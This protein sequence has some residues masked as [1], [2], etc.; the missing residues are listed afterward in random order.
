MTSDR[1]AEIEAI[2]HQTKDIELNKRTAFLKDA[3]A[4]DPSLLKEVESLLKAHEEAPDFF[5]KPAWSFVIKKPRMDK[6]QLK[7]LIPEPGL[8]F[9]K[10]GEFK[11]IRRIGQGGMGEVFLAVQES[12]NRQA[13]IKVIRL[14]RAHSLDTAARFIREIEAISKLNHPNIVTIYNS[15]EEQGVHYY[16]MELLSGKGMDE[17][18]KEDQSITLDQKLFWIKEIAWALDSAHK[19]G[20]IHR[21]V[22]P[23]NIQIQKDGRPVLLD[24]GVARHMN[25]ATLTLSGEFRGTPHYAS[26]EQVKAKK[27]EITALTD[28]YSLGVTLYEAMTRKVPFQGETTD[29]V[30]L[31]ILEKDPQKPRRINPSISPDL[32]TVILKAMEKAPEH[33]YPTMAELAQDL[34]RVI[35]RKMILAKP[36]GLIKSAWKKSKRRPLVS[37]MIG[38][39]V[40]ALLYVLWS[41]PQILWERN[42]AEKQTKAA[43][44]AK[45]Q[46]E[47]E[48]NKATIIR[49]YL[50]TMLSSPDPGKDGKEVR[51]VDL[52]DKFA[53]EVDKNFAKDPEI[54]ASIH[55]TLGRTYKGLGQYTAA[56]KQH[57]AALKIYQSLW[58]KDHKDALDTMNCLAVLYSLLGR[59]QEA[60]ELFSQVLDTHIREFGEGNLKTTAIMDNLATVLNRL[61]Q[62]QWA[63]KLH[64]QVLENF[65]KSVGPEHRD[66]LI[67]M[68]NLANVLKA[69]GK[70]SEAVP[71]HKKTYETMIRLHGEKHPNCLGAMFNLANAF[72]QIGQYDDAEKLFRKVYQVCSS[73]LGDTHHRTLLS[74]TGIGDVLLDQNRLD[75]AES[76]IKEAYA[77]LSFVLEKDHPDTLNALELLAIT[78]YKQGRYD[79]A[80]AHHKKVLEA[81]QKKLSPDHPSILQS[82]N[83]L[84]CVLSDQNKLK[85]AEALFQDVIQRIKRSMPNDYLYTS[86]YVRNYGDCLLKMKRYAQA[87]EKLLKSY[88]TLKDKLG[89]EH[90]QTKMTADL[91]QKLYKD[92]KK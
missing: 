78:C 66:T 54:Q 56:E 35:S 81:R 51:V 92:W 30:F 42:R 27:G 34:E 58:G 60:K 71:L 61:G 79:E 69:Q 64:R 29:Q 14:E 62:Y 83:N 65:Q 22:K 52:L 49:R 20:I 68:N 47:K 43:V 45:I 36:D 63:E 48:A 24:F 80:A 28:V 55:N 4:H 5:K 73:W 26:P 74:K 40:V 37:A 41:Y 46:A 6:S 67:A 32:E 38:V 90:L 33:R 53:K 91:V 13:A 75:E 2:F 1:T 18:L 57:E 21:D 82:M 87:E 70:Y 85:E 84:A 31:Q 12:L 10:L 44:A 16:A 25:L 7:E 15:G 76:L 50:E 89:E 23:S 3:C 39:V 19:I 11:L 77:S 17:I 86:M 72:Q 8:P 88:E 59:D 9:E